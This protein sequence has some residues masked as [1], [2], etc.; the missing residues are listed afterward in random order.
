M[1]E[2]EH[3]IGHDLSEQGS[4][5]EIHQMVDG[6]PRAATPRRMVTQARVP[7]GELDQWINQLRHDV[8]THGLDN[9]AFHQRV[10]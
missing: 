7:L 3:R 4:S 10:T 9:D 1:I 6:Q 2:Y 8:Q 5:D